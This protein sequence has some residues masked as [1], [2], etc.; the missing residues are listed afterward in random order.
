M[1]R[2]KTETLGGFPLE[3]D[4]LTFRDTA[5][6]D[7][8]KGVLTSFNRDFVR[9][10]GL[11]VTN[12]LG[13]LLVTA[14]YVGYNGEVLYIPPSTFTYNASA[15]LY[16]NLSVVD[17]NVE[18]FQDGTSHATEELRTGV[19]GY[20]DT[21]VLG[22]PFDN[23]LTPQEILM[24]DLGINEMNQVKHKKLRVTFPAFTWNGTYWVSQVLHGINFGD[25]SKVLNTSVSFDMEPSGLGYGIYPLSFIGVDFT[26]KTNDTTCEILCFQANPSSDDARSLIEDNVAHIVFTHD[27][28]SL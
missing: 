9:L 2:L 18:V 4:D 17:A 28:A 11:K 3:G 1:N 8:F 13:S 10:S 25:H 20:S 26:V 7:A 15:T 27:N 19:L 22:E 24:I 14:G 16:I 12:V 23:F 6:R 21:L 5:F